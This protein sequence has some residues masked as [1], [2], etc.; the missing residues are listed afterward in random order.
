VRQAAIVKERYADFCPT[1]A[2]EKL[3]EQ[4]A[5]TLSRETW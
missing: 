1:L 3:R 4:H 5:M 2:A